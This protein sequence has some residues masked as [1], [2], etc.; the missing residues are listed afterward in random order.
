MGVRL[1]C[2]VALVLAT[3]GMADIEYDPSVRDETVGATKVSGDTPLGGQE[4]EGA[5]T[6]P[7]AGAALVRQTLAGDVGAGLTLVLQGTVVTQQAVQ[8]EAWEDQHRAQQDGAQEP[9]QTQWM[10]P[11]A[12]E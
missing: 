12:D 6:P 4:V 5:V 2:P 8:A 9:G 1:G 3:T 10:D 7:G 11:Q